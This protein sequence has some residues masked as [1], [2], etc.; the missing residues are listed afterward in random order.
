MKTRAAVAFEAVIAVVR[1]VVVLAR[2]EDVVAVAADQVVVVGS[3]A[4]QIAADQLKGLGV[5]AREPMTTR[6]TPASNSAAT[7]LAPR[8]PPPRRPSPS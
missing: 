5:T 4:Q 6:E 8:T 7:S 2:F 3:A 1:V